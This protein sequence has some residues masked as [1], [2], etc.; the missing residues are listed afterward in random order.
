MT[1]DTPGWY[2]WLVPIYVIHQSRY[3]TGAI[4]L[5]AFFSIL[6]ISYN[7][8]YSSGS[9]I[10]FLNLHLIDSI[11]FH[12]LISKP[13]HYTLM[14]GFGLLIAIQL[15]REGIRENDFYRLGNRPVSIG[16]AGDSG[17][18]K[19]TFSKGLSSI[20]GK[21]SIAEVAGDDYHNW[22]RASP[23]WKTITHLNPKGNKLFQLVK[24]VRS[25]MNGSPVVAR[26]YNHTTGKFS[27]NQIRA[28]KD[29]ILVEGLHT[30][31][32]RQ[33]IEELDVRIFIEMNESLKLYF[34]VNRDVKERGQSEK[35]VL[36]AIEKRKSD[37]QKYIKP[38]ALRADVIFSLVPNN[39]ELLENSNSLSP[40]LKLNVS[41]KNGIYY[42]ELVKVLIGICGLQVNIASI[43]E[44]GEV[45]IEISGDIMAEDVELAVHMLIPNMEELFNFNAKFAIGMHGIMQI[46]TL[47]ELDEALKRRRLV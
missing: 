6:F 13:L 5:I 2:L 45:I 19:S 21:S 31:Y 34:R 24:D 29:V 30:L 37:S 20:F 38:Q 8:I 35:Q 28:S 44:N 12:N 36:D 23:M 7:L 4:S 25:L 10:L 9:E 32:P 43:D 26:S 17:V 3:G 15:L 14:V 1:P 11:N 41:I 47:M 33:L 40:N 39:P 16:I 22:D 42:D 27:P 46:I 18:G